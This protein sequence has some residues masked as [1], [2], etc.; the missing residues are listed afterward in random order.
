MWQRF[1]RYLPLSSF[2]S[3]LFSPS[4]HTSHLPFFILL[5]CLPVLP[6][7]SLLSSLP[8]PP[9]T[10]SSLFD[11][12]RRKKNSTSHHCAIKSISP[13]AMVI[14]LDTIT[15]ATLF[16]RATGRKWLSRSPG[17]DAQSTHAACI[18]T[19]LFHVSLSRSN[20]CAHCISPAW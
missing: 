7:H 18:C 12:Q 5:L 20:E 2:S 17:G 15:I 8:S 11:L 4:L 9:L 19:A 10:K 16:S 1:H 13:V 14:H 3:L 6:L